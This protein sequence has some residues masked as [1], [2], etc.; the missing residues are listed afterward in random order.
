[1]Q[2]FGSEAHGRI[3]R[4]QEISDGR[5]LVFIEG[6]ANRPGKPSC[7][8]PV[9]YFAVVNENSPEGRQQIAMLRDAKRNGLAVDIV[10]TGDCRRWVDSEGISYLG[11]NR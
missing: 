6:A 7:V 2:V 1:M 10:G 11:I 3:E 9:G 8:H 4:L 5:V